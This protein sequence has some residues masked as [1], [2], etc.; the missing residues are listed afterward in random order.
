[1]V[2]VPG[3]HVLQQIG[4]IRA[5]MLRGLAADL[6]GTT[7]QACHFSHEERSSFTGFLQ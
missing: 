5:E 4:L 3:P 1:M 6:H 2:F 7:V